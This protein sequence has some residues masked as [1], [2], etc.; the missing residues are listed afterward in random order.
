[1]RV[2]EA[3]VFLPD[4]PAYISWDQ[5]QHN[6]VQLRSNR[7]AW[8]G[9]VGA[10]SALLCGVLI[11]GRSGLRM[12]ANYNNNGRTARYACSYMKASYAEPF[13]QSLKAA[14]LDALLTPLVLQALQ[15]AAL[16]TSLALAADLEG[17]D[18]HWQQR[19]ER[20]RYEAERAR[21]QYGAVES[22][23]RLVAR[24][25]ER[26]WEEQTR[27]KADYERVRRERLEGRPNSSRPAIWR[28]IWRRFG[29]PRPR[30]RR[31]AGPSS[32][33][34]SSACWSRWSDGE[35]I[36]VTCLFCEILTTT[37]RSHR[38]R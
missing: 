25:L 29:V 2:E 6:Q 23:S 30:P 32:D 12:N 10:G 36:R 11:C 38:A 19:L 27:L 26:V 4:V 28:R 8:G 34:C 15:L 18:R 37:G 21:P 14:P 22:E 24:T 7:A 31:S 17:L 1:L 35:Q 33:C 5:Y 13:C 16:E 9:S 3:D 20:A